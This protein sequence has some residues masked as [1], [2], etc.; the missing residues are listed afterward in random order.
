VKHTLHPARTVIPF[1]FAGL[2]S[3]AARPALAA[4]P[5]YQAV[6]SCPAA[7]EFTSQLLPAGPEVNP[8]RSVLSVQRIEGGYEASLRVRLLE[9]D[10]LVEESRESRDC[11]TAVRWAAA[12]W[13]IKY[14]R[15]SQRPGLVL[16]LGSGLSLAKDPLLDVH[17]GLDLDYSLLRGGMGALWTPKQTTSGG[18][19]GNP[20][21]WTHWA[22]TWR[23]CELTGE[24]ESDFRFGACQLLNLHFLKF[25]SPLLQAGLSH[26]L[27]WLDLGLGAFAQYRALAGLSIEALLSA[28]Y[29]LEPAHV[30]GD[31]WGGIEFPSYPIS[32]PGRGSPDRLGFQLT[33]RLNYDVSKLLTY[34]TEQAPLVAALPNQQW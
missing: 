20:I 26:N 29:V 24:P 33:L 7:T 18:D 8:D 31:A 21:D 11:F 14:A 28:S 30:S 9:G 12:V 15:Q 27:R 4:L 1:V 23:I 22:L 3:L 6:E 19:Q 25:D 34:R 5:A 2:F 16:G 10:A 13:N 17:G 32:G